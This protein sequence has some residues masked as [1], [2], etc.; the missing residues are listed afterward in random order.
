MILYQK[1]LISNSFW[2][3]VGLYAHLFS[4]AGFFCGLSLYRSCTCFS[5]VVNSALPRKHYFLVR[6]SVLSI[7]SFS[8]SQS[9]LSL[10]FNCHLLQIKTV[11][12]AKR[13]TSQQ[14]TNSIRNCFCN[15]ADGI[16]TLYIIY[17]GHLFIFISFGYFYFNL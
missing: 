7:L 2:L 16:L 6:A 13:Q 1:L 4:P 3:G 9:I 11:V 5:T 8:A 15:T 17:T 14:Y 10:C 12:N